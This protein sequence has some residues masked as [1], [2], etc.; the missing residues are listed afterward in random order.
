[1]TSD[2]VLAGSDDHYSWMLST[3]VLM[4]LPPNSF[5]G[6]CST[7]GTVIDV[8]RGDSTTPSK[9]DPGGGPGPV[10]LWDRCFLFASRH[11]I[12]VCTQTY[13]FRCCI[14]LRQL[15]ANC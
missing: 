8:S 14:V 5:Q 13:I 3:S 10:W 11:L 7:T 1:M 4:I 9:A 12:G 15:Y 6:Y 2:E